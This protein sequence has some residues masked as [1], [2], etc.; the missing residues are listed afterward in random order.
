MKNNNKPFPFFF[1]TVELL[2][3]IFFPY[4]IFIYKINQKRELQRSTYFSSLAHNSVNLVCGPYIVLAVF[5]PRHH[6][7][8]DLPNV[9][10]P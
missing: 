1:F 6:N 8:M 3:I 10:T 2:E 4:M 7:L 9:K 5:C